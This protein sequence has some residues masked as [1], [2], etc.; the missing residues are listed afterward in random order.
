MTVQAGTVTGGG[1]SGALRA[2][3]RVVVL[4]AILG[5]VLYPLLWMLGSSLKSPTEVASN[6]SVIPTEPT[7][8]NYPDGWSYIKGIS[9][10]RFFTNSLVIA[11]AT[12]VAN[13]VSCLVTA[14]AFARLHFRGRRVWFAVMIATLLLPSH[15]LIIPQYV[16]F[17]YFGWIDTPLPLIVPKLLATEAFFVFLMVQFMR[18]I[19]R[20]LDQAA[21]IDG[22][23]PYGV[24][25][26]VILPLSR[27]AL[28]TTAIFS[29]IWT[30]NDFFTQLVYLPSPS[31]YTV[32]IGLRLFIDSSGQTSLGPMF[33][34]SVLSLAPVFLFFL[35]FQRMLVEGINTSG[36]KG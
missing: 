15:V 9:F 27:P 28:V 12:V 17:N 4:V 22:C 2:V 23:S 6:L 21:K 16:L 31:S 26:Y 1:S 20:E 29:F 32:P 36:L 13:G 7:W 5:F 18:G 24:F 30:W 8:A 35:A 11:L 34:M 10:G 33:A 25:R 3:G 14:Y 19:P